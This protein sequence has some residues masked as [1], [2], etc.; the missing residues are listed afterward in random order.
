MVRAGRRVATGLL[1]G[2]L[3]GG[4]AAGGSDPGRGEIF[5]GS[6]AMDTP[7]AMARRLAPLTDYLTARIGR[8]VIFRASP[9][10]GSAVYDLGTDYT[11]IA[12][13][14]PVAYIEGRSKFNVQP[15]VVPVHQGSTTFTLAIVVRQDSS[16]KSIAD[17]R[18][19]AFAFGDEKALLQRAVVVNSGLPMDALGSYAFLKHYDAIAKA[20]ING[21]FAA[22]IMKSTLVDEQFSKDLRILYR[23]PPLPAYVFAVSASLPPGAVANLRRALTSL[24]ADNDEHRAVL[25]TLDQAYEGFVAAKDSDYDVVRRL[26]EPFVQAGP[27]NAPA[28]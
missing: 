28:P 17:L 1:V 2:L 12:Y 8:P 10:L 23:S 22:G 24:R 20:V 15:L 9:N 4:P 27:V 7:A 25:S 14:T 16:I 19:S 18:G 3:C 13:L 5:L 21:D 11:Q 26:I 6:V